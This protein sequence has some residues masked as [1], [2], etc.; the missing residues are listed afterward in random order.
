M[1]PVAFEDTPLTR[2]INMQVSLINI[3]AC[4]FVESLRAVD[5]DVVHCDVAAD[6]RARADQRANDRV[7]LLAGGAFE[8]LDSNV[9]DG[10]RRRKLI[11][12]RQIGLAVALRDF[13]GIVD[14]LNGHSVVKDVLDSAGTAAAL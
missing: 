6:I 3:L 12:E 11:A 4:K 9:G 14:V 5:I 1:P 7:V 2:A 8:V 13:D 10:Q